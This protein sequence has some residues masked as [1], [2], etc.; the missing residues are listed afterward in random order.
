LILAP[1]REP[2]FAHEPTLVLH[3]LACDAVCT[4][5]VLVLRPAPARGACCPL[6][7]KLLLLLLPAAVVVAVAAA[8]HAAVRTVAA[9]AAAGCYW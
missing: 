3:L 7:L 8:P 1:A 9:A 6:W 5:I 2:K 4:L